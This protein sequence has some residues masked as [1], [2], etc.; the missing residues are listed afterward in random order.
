M[1]LVFAE[2]NGEYETQIGGTNVIVASKDQV[3]EFKERIENWLSTCNLIIGVAAFNLGLGSAG[4]SNVPLHASVSVLFLLTLHFYGYKLFTKSFFG[5]ECRTPGLSSAE[6]AQATSEFRGFIR[7]KYFP[8]RGM[9]LKTPIWI[10]GVAY[11]FFV[12]L[13]AIATL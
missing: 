11:L 4:T 5:F 7:V 8:Y 9:V 3:D 6:L 13:R 12:F 2:V 10:F 1:G